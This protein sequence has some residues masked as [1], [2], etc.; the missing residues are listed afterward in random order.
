VV[1]PSRWYETFGRVVV[2]AY[3]CGRP[4][5]ASRIGALA[6]LVPDHALF[7]AGNPESLAEAV[8]RALP[9]AVRLGE[10]ARREYESKYRPEQNYRM[11]MD[12]YRRVLA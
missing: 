5:V 9:D 6:E 1:V 2:E 10:A 4:V 12:A 3:A 11:M 8:A 7:E